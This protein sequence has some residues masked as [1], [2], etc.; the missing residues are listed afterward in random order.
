M[1]R[2]IMTLLALLMV[3]AGLT[4]VYAQSDRGIVIRPIAPT[5]GTVKGDQWLLVI[6]IDNYL[7]WPKLKTAVNDFKKIFATA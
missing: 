2:P 4:L 6:G 1:K 3:I 5:G 7:Q